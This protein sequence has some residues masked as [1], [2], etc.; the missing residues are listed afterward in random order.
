[1]GIR[2][3]QATSQEFPSQPDDSLPN[4]GQRPPQDK[5]GSQMTPPSDLQG[6]MPQNGQTRLLGGFGGARGGFGLLRWVGLGLYG[7]VVILAIVTAV[8][9]LQAKKWAAILAIILAG[10][11]T[12]T[13][14]SSFFGLSSTIG[15][16]VGIVRVV[17]GI[18]IIVLLLLSQS[19]AIWDHP[20]VEV[21]DDDDE[22]DEDDDDDKKDEQEDSQIID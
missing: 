1:M 13:G 22:D 19:R 9:L 14:I 6:R 12:I 20:K 2:G 3:S 5:N 7:V 16:I 21:V 4:L 8:F 10:A 11:L 15:L 18:S 17:L